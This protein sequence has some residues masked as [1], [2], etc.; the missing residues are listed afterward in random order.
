V[1]VKFN[2]SYNRKLGPGIV[3]YEKGE[4]RKGIRLTGFFDLDEF[5]TRKASGF[6][7]HFLIIQ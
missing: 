2:R 1:G 7:K 5:K 6:G 4:M 3:I